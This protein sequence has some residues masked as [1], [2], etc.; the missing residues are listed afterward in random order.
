[1]QVSDVSIDIRQFAACEDKATDGWIGCR[2]AL[3]QGRPIQD[4]TEGSARADVTRRWHTAVALCWC[5][6][7]PR[8]APPVRVL[9]HLVGQWWCSFT[10]VLVCTTVEI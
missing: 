3:R 4:H 7:L 2:V 9:Q 8:E 10:E 6:A 5:R 1:M